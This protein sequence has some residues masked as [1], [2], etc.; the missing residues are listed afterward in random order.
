[1]PIENPYVCNI[2]WGTKWGIKGHWSN[3]ESSSWGLKIYNEIISKLHM[4]LA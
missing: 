4:Q 2:V 3:N 1:M